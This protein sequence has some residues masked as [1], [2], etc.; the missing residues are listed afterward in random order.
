MNL[1]ASSS[2]NIMN[3]GEQLKR[4]QFIGRVMSLEE[5]NIHFE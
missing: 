3:S 4:F 5:M 1:L 2:R